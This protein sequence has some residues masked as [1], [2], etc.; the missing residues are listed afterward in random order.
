M[1]PW[2]SSGGWLD[3]LETIREGIKKGGS[4]NS[5]S[6][7]LSS[8]E[9]EAR[10]FIIAHESGGN[11]SARNPNNPTVYGAYQLKLAYLKGDL[12]KENQDRTAQSYMKERYGT[13]VKAKEFW[14]ANNWW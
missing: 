1:P 6:S 14:V 5:S 3:P 9:D 8:K 12:S 2:D 10:K 13:W 4:G 7:G 11:Y